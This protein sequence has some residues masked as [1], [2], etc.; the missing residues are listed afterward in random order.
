MGQDA[1]RRRLDIIELTEQL[2]AIPSISGNETEILH[3]VASWMQSV[4]FDKVITE[5]RFTTGLIRASK[6]PAQRALIL[7]GHVD[8]VSPGDESAWQQSP[9]QPYVMNGRLYSLGA[10]NYQD[11]KSVV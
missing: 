2:I 3:F 7:C 4:N 10:T 5:K 9:W 11:R 1:K 8:T 6:Q